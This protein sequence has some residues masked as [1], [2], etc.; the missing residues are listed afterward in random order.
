MSQ[1]FLVGVDGSAFAEQSLSYVAALLGERDELVLARV[2]DPQHDSPALA[3]AYLDRLVE[4]LRKALPVAP[5]TRLEYGLPQ[6]E[7]PRVARE[8]RADLLV[9]STHSR[10]GLKRWLLGSVAEAVARQAPCPV[11]LAPARE[12]PLQLLVEPWETPRSPLGNLLIPLDTSPLAD[13]ALD[14]V[15]VWPSAR[16][17]RLVL[18]AATDMR[19][20]DRK[21]NARLRAHLRHFLEERA[22]P[23]LRAGWRV[24]TRVEDDLAYEAVL[25]AARAEKF[26]AVVMATHGRTGVDRY[27]TG[28]LA[29]SVA[30]R[31][32]CPTVV[33]PP[34]ARFSVSAC[35]GAPR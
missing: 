20:P 22:A 13:R 6:D 12:K 27:L 4:R 18:L 28:S 24:E 5:H 29:E 2:A 23:L 14:F 34:E 25:R 16:W 15:R 35:A 7:L 26:Q 1:R 32:G 10:T 11:W 31:C 30:R 8:E 33:V 21:L 3:Q 9:L 19:P 17:A